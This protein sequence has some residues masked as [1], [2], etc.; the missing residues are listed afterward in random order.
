MKDRTIG[1]MRVS[2]MGLGCMGMSE[3]YGS[4]SEEESISTLHHAVHLGV[5]LFD[6]ADQYGLGANE[7]LVGKALAPFRKELYLATKF[8]YVR[9]EKGEF[10][11]INGRPD[12]V[13]K[14]CDASLKR[15]GTDYI[16]LY[17]LHRVDP[18][19]PIEETVGA[20]K[21]LID[22]GKV[23]FI[24]LSE[25]SAETIRRAVRIHPIAALQSEYSLWSREAEEH[26]LP[27]CRELGISFVPYSPLGRGF[28]SGKMTS[29]EQLDA[30]D[31]R[32]RTPRFQGDNLAVNIGLVQKLTAIA[33]EM[34]ITAPQLALA[35]VLANGD[36]LIP[37]PGTKK[38]HYLEENL[39]ALDMGLPEDVKAQL[40]EM[41]PIGTAAGERYP[42][43]MMTLLDE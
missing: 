17:Y 43:H 39:A 33:R 31:Y 16:D 37:I 20:M 32:R 34:N 15:L 8:G 14:A 29:A 6:T 23:R 11:E 10:I 19:V 35:W 28:L 2:A 30:D 1:S 4:Q 18:R 7:E 25:A 42:K 27:A 13:K 12:Y 41:F 3:Y 5:N 21:E 26:V 24:G 38:K 36:D 40:D 22:E 9:S